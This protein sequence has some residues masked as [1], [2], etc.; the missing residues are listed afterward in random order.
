MSE[1]I[2]PNQKRFWITCDECRDVCNQHAYKESTFMGRLKRRF[3]HL[4]CSG[5]REYAAM[6]KQI[7][8]LVTSDQVHY[9]SQ[10]DR[11]GLDDLISEARLRELDEQE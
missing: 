4:F 5:C 10:E 1:P 2:T 6:N 11:D 9:L 3:H 7:N 8:R